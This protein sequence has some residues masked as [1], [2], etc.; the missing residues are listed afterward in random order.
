MSLL[1]GDAGKNPLY[2][3][4]K[5]NKMKDEIYISRPVNKLAALVTGNQPDDEMEAT[6][7]GDTYMSLIR[8]PTINFNSKKSWLNLAGLTFG[9]FTVIGMFIKQN[10]KKKMKWVVHCKCGY[11][12]IRNSNVIRRKIKDNEY[13]E[14]SRCRK[15]SQSIRNCERSATIY[16]NDSSC[17]Y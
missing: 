4:I 5:V 11:Y 3:I 13:D 2:L 17:K 6:S 12:T 15:V 7:Y 16:F 10:P 9:K 8:P 1:L 14:C